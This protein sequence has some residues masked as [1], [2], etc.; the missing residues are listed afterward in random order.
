MSAETIRLDRD[1]VIRVEDGSA[2]VRHGDAE[3]RFT[4]SLSNIEVLADR[5]LNGAREVRLR[6][7][8]SGSPY[9]PPTRGNV[10]T[11]D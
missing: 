11:G 10:W 6:Q 1:T 2:T 4:G 9:S 8:S 7:E 5:L 3:V